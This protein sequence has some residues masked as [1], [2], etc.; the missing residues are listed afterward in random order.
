MKLLSLVLLLFC[1][2]FGSCEDRKK[3]SEEKIAPSKESKA[4]SL[5]ETETSAQKTSE[6]KQTYPVITDENVVEFLTQY[7]KQNLETKVRI[8]TQHGVIEVQLFEDT[9][10]HRANFIY[11]VKRKYFDNTFFHRIAPGF[12]I[13]GGNSDL[14]STPEKRA[15]IG[16]GYRLPAEISGKRSHSYG[17]VVGAKEY[18][19][20]PDKKSAP[21]EFYIFIGE[22]RQANHLNGDYTIFGK[23]TKGMDVVDTIAHLPADEGEWP[24]QNVYI[25]AEVIE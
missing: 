13:Q 14:P 19:E 8:T 18:R 6:E 15:E 10:L 24:L 5:N 20:N 11:L 9:P 4:D 2:A 23:V 12:I 21:F 25:T 17:S 7:G 3:T 22:P 16:K 1:I